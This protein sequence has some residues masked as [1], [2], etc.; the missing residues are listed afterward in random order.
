MDGFEDMLLEDLGIGT[1]AP[2]TQK[3][4]IVESLPA[5]R[6][7]AG[8]VNQYD[9]GLTGF[10][11][12]YTT[13]RFSRQEQMIIERIRESALTQE[14]IAGLVERAQ[15]LSGEQRLNTAMRLKSEAQTYF[16]IRDIAMAENRELG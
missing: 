7:Q 4:E 6:G 13:R 16:L 15:A 5:R 11:P 12:P 9:T 8:L 2:P 1:G 14:G 3:G 10:S